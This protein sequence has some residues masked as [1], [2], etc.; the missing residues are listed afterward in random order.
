VKSLHWRTLHVIT[1]T[2][3]CALLAIYFVFK[4]IV[5]RPFAQLED[6][7]LRDDTVRAIAA[8]H[9]S[10][11]ALDTTA[12]DWAAWD[13]TYTFVHDGNDTYRDANLTAT[14]YQSLSLN[15]L[16]IVDETGRITYSGAFDLATGQFVPLPDGLDRYLAADGPLMNW[17]NLDTGTSG[18]LSLPQGLLL[19][20]SRPILTNEHQGPAHGALVMGRWLDNAFVAQLAANTHLDLA[21][22][23]VAAIQPGSD[24]AQA[25]ALL[26]TPETLYV[27][28]V[29]VS[30]GVGYSLLDDLEGQPTA[31]VTVTA[32]RPIYEQ[33]LA[34][35]RYLQAAVSAVALLLIV[36]NV[37][38]VDRH[39]VARRAALTREV[40]DIGEN[41]DPDHRVPTP[42]YHDEL[43]SLAL[44]INHT[45]DNL[46][47]SEKERRRV[48]ELLAQS[49][50][51]YRLLFENS[52]VSLWEEDFSAV[53]AYLGELHAKGSR[54][55]AAT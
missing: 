46:A 44:S 7:A 43:A 12:N 30:T 31:V 13:D 29:N 15:V 51:D 17:A 1:V 40:A 3:V 35:V 37:A 21:V 54:T 45:L 36:V 19:V 42:K 55:W 9:T 39:V 25:F 41:P 50:K 18:L 10:L 6:Q 32:P 49:E 33:G 34:T 4:G 38:W 23:P 14:V 47:H 22:T 27:H 8:L 53:K 11:A 20:V 2:A 48:R 16:A 52:P 28:A 5:M 26:P 24:L